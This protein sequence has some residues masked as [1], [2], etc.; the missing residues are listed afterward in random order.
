M[1]GPRA[2][3]GSWP[4]AFPWLCSNMSRHDALGPEMHLSQNTE[5]EGEFEGLGS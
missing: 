5:Q 1:Q 4:S 2:V 3:E